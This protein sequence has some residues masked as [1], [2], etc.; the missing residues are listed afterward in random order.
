MLNDT[1]VAVATPQGSGGM[2]VI[3]VSG[4]KSFEIVDKLFSENVINQTPRTILHGNFFNF[5]GKTIDDVVITKFQG[6]HSYTGEDVIEISSHGNII[7]VEE[8]INS[9][10]EAGGV[11]AES[12]NL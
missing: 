10:L 7:I 8:I 12:R 2:S 4:E 6:P 3:R 1:I 9:I 11:I 5:E